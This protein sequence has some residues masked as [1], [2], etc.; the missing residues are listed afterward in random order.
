MMTQQPL[1]PTLQQQHHVGSQHHHHHHHNPSHLQGYF[2]PND[3]DDDSD[4]SSSFNQ[5]LNFD[6]ST[7][8]RHHQPL[9]PPSRS[10]SQPLTSSHQ[11]Q[12]VYYPAH[13]YPQMIS[14]MRP[15]PLLPAI[16]RM[17]DLTEMQAFGDQ[18]ALLFV[19]KLSSSLICPVHRGVLAEP[20]LVIVCGHTFCRKC[21][22]VS[23]ILSPPTGPSSR[24]TP[25]PFF[26]YLC[27]LLCKSGILPNSSP[28]CPVDNKVMSEKDTVPN[29]ALSDQ[30]SD[31]PIL[32]RFGCKTF[33]GQLVPDQEGCQEVVKFGQREAHER[34]CPYALLACPN[35]ALCEK[36]QR[37]ALQG[38]LEV[39]RRTLCV[40]KEAGCRFEGSKRDIDRHLL[41]CQ[42]R[43][44][45]A[46]R[47]STGDG[48]TSSTVG[49]ASSEGEDLASMRRMLDDFAEKIK[50]LEDQLILSRQTTSALAQEVER[51][52]ANNVK[53]LE[54]VQEQM[55]GKSRIP[56]PRV[57][58]VNQ[59]T[60]GFPNE[61]IMPFVFNC[62]GTFVT[63]D[64]QVWC[65]H[66]TNNYLVSGGSR[67]TIKFW[68]LSMRRCVKS[69]VAHTGIVYC[70]GS[71]GGLLYSGGED[72]MLRSWRIDT[73]EENQ[74]VKAGND[75]VSSLAVTDRHLI[76]GSLATIKVWNCLNLTCE[77]VLTGLAHWVWVR[78]LA[79]DEKKTRL[80]SGTHNAIQI[81]D[82]TTFQCLTTIN[83][84]YGTIY[85]FILTPK[86]LVCGTYNQNIQ[87]Y[88]MT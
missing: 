72:C 52:R 75:A 84:S 42:F 3:G 81:W 59:T 49:R 66:Y 12:Q 87:L 73:F 7:V 35:S 41:Q 83:T 54:Y 78:A 79:L 11:Q 32:C 74:S 60:K 1:S 38:H 37:R 51:E 16:Q 40:N 24:L 23:A 8:G 15:Q 30:I 10:T 29:L 71:V 85:S 36:V 48:R 86:F 69:I 56:N 68:D 43:T 67:G 70:L 6:S 58:K 9:S 13:G 47:S 28:K 31:L 39:C 25:F 26:S 65:L 80:F 44:S 14:S 55:R 64:E 88:E 18:P 77:H 57:R 17:E 34:G 27:L 4:T 82:T 50:F 19:G 2:L 33:N 21:I 61:L 76:T 22:E 63:T 45:P 46:P 62:S 20:L 53:V 5:E